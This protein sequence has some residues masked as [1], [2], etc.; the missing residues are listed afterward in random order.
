[1]ILKNTCGQQGFV[2][3]LSYKPVIGRAASNM[4]HPPCRQREKGFCGSVSYP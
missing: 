2:M 3:V 4:K 1:M